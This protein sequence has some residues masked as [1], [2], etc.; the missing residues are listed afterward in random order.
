MHGAADATSE[1]TRKN[2]DTTGARFAANAA[3]DILA[4]ARERLNN[5]DYQGAFRESKDAIRMASSALLLRDGYVA[6]T[7]EATIRYIEERHSGQLPIE[8][9]QYLENMLTG[10]GPGLLNLIVRFAGKNK[11]TGKQEASQAMAIAERFVAS[12]MAIIELRA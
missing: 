11:K 4:M 6:S 3:L 10:E 8:E 1:I 2:P 9:W 12:V 5:R 7:F